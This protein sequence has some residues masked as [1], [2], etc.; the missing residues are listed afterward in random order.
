MNQGKLLAEASANAWHANA[1]LHAEAARAWEEEAELR[2]AQIAELQ[3]Q[4]AQR[5]EFRLADHNTPESLSP[6][7]KLSHSED[8]EV[9]SPRLMLQDSETQT[10]PPVTNYDDDDDDTNVSKAETADA[11]TMT[12]QLEIILPS[13]QSQLSSPSPSPAPPN[14]PTPSKSTSTSTSTPSV[15][16]P[17]I[18][19]SDDK[20]LPCEDLSTSAFSSETMAAV[21]G[22]GIV[23][24]KIRVCHLSLK[25]LMDNGDAEEKLIVCAKALYAI[26]ALQLN[27]VEERPT[28]ILSLLQV[29]DYYQVLLT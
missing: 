28:M 11:Q 21:D 4:L 6:V 17:P 7:F 22:V 27:K 20:L 9:L 15:S 16:G 26:N 29:I 25:E 3:S 12:S 19:S 2:A 1:S 5:K 10:T 8:H 18:V 13:S 14:D 24:E 23:E